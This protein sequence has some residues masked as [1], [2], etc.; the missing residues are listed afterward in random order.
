MDDYT[1]EVLHDFGGYVQIM[2]AGRRRKRWWLAIQG[3]PITVIDEEDIPH[4]VQVFSDLQQDP[5]GLKLQQARQNVVDVL[6]FIDAK[7]KYDRACIIQQVT[8]LA[9]E[10]AEYEQLMQGDDDNSRLA[11]DF[12]D[13]TPF[14]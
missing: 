8:E 6:G 3:T 10:E 5:Q 2:C 4:Y 1:Y 12:H 11:D 9:I 14:F 7:A 13:D